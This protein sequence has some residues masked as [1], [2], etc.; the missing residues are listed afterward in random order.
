M[1]IL[2]AATKKAMIRQMMNAIKEMLADKTLPKSTCE[3]L[4]ALDGDLRKT[5]ET[6]SASGEDDQAESLHE[7][8]TIGTRLEGELHSQFVDMVDDLYEQ[9]AITRDELQTLHQVVTDAIDAVYSAIM[10]DCPQLYDRSP[11]MDAPEATGEGEMQ[12]AGQ[13]YQTR[14][15]KK[16]HKG[17]FFYAPEGINPSEW[18]LL[19][20]GTPGGEPDAT[21]VG[22]AAA[23]LG[24][25]PPHGKKVKIPAADLPAVKA[26]IRAAWKK[27]NPDKKDDEMP[28]VIK[29]AIRE[30]VQLIE[31]IDLS[32]FTPLREDNAS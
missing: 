16:Y 15:G 22:Q 5:W 1:K 17:D 28:E 2:E 26:S 32:E 13:D 24:P 14:D 7:S 3:H 10:Q 29:E 8:M 21:H 23:A 11:F 6:L 20:T 25:N 9:G 19:K 31:S 18:A 4:E 27:A 30:S 12:E